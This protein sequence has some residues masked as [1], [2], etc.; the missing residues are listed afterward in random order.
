MPICPIHNN[1]IT[2]INSCSLCTEQLRSSN[3]AKAKELQST[4][5]K[6]AKK[7]SK[8]QPATSYNVSSLKGFRTKNKYNNVTTEYNG[9]KYDSKLEAK[10][11]QDLDWRLKAGDII[12][13]RRQVK[14]PLHVNG[15]FIAN[16]YI[17]FIYTD[18]NG[19]VTYLEV[20]GLELAVWALKWKLL[21]A[22]INEIEPGAKLQVVKQK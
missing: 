16:Y 7:I 21:T 11:A 13:W 20:K 17:D 2:S 12:E 6:V 9:I 10:V 4:A 8:S 3:R 18:K 19:E 14:I 5:V 1:Y 22:L 15:V